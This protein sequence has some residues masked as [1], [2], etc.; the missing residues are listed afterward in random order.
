M[1]FEAPSKKSKTEIIQSGIFKDSDTVD[2]DFCDDWAYS[3]WSA[4]E[5]PFEKALKNSG[6]IELAIEFISQV[7]NNSLIEQMKNK[8]MLDVIDWTDLDNV[9]YILSNCIKKN[10]E[11]LDDIVIEYIKF[12]NVLSTFTVEISLQAVYGEIKHLSSEVLERW[13]YKIFTQY[14]EFDV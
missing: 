9:K 8:N 2:C 1:N 12:D 14:G 10:W 7:P 5:D 13:D 11:D 6:L 4:D 3:K